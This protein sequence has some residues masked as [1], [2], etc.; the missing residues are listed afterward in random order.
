MA[1]NVIAL[2]CS[3][4]IVDAFASRPTDP[5]PVWPPPYQ[6][7]T[8][9]L[10][11]WAKSA[12]ACSTPKFWSTNW[13]SYPN[14]REKCPQSQADDWTEQTHFTLMNYNELAPQRFLSR[15]SI[16]DYLPLEKDHATYKDLID[17]Y[18]FYPITGD[19]SGFRGPGACLR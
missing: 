19:G 12:S 6:P 2:L 11:D 18:D 17:N 3:A 8:K 16:D 9:S 13:E 14:S 4:A 5:Q 10:W 7:D 15:G 1:T